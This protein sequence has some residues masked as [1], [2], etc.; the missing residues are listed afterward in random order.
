MSEVAQFQRAFPQAACWCTTIFGIP[1]ARLA[2]NADFERG[3]KNLK[4]GWS[5][6]NVVTLVCRTIA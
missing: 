4:N 6:A 2:A 1:P 5:A 3:R